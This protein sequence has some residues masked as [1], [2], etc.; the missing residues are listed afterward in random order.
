MGLRNNLVRIPIMSS[1][2]FVDDLPLFRSTVRR[3]RHGLQRS[4]IHHPLNEAA[5]RQVIVLPLLWAAGFDIFDPEE[6]AP[7]VTDPSGG[8]VDLELRIDGKTRC[9]LELKRIGASLNDKA[10]VQAISYAVAKGIRWAIATNG[11]TWRF[12][13]THIVEKPA[14]EKDVLELSMLDNDEEE[15]AYNL[16]SVL[17]KEN[18]ETD[19]FVISSIRF[20]LGLPLV[21]WRITHQNGEFK[22]PLEAGIV[23]VGRD[24]QNVLPFN[25]ATLSKSHAIFALQDGK[26]ILTDLNSTNGTTVNGIKIVP[27]VKTLMKHGDVLVLG[28]MRFEVRAG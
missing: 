13:D 12:F 9:V 24:S 11:V 5:T 17:H 26:L 25:N 14:L 27:N 19:G 15:L 3:I 23:S 28:D 7:E 1:D 2:P 10:I 22:L 18:W 8:R 4:W 16:F 20:V 21:S 6:V